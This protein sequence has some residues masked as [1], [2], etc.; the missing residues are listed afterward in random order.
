MQVEYAD[1]QDVPAVTLSEM[2]ERISSRWVGCWSSSQFH[3][4]T[5]TRA[6]CR[7][8]SWHLNSLSM[9][10]GCIILEIDLAQLQN[11]NA[12]SFSPPGDM[13]LVDWLN[14]VQLQKMAGASDIGAGSVISIKVSSCQS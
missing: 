8:P 9:R 1:L 6:P 11:H 13:D 7:C 3:G 12:E 10:A 2:Q 14:L 5:L 4:I